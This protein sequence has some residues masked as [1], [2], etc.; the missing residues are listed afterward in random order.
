M[1]QQ[2]KICLGHINEDNYL[3]GYIVEYQIC[4]KFQHKTKQF[5]S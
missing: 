1:D 4:I 3:L 2:Y 5:I